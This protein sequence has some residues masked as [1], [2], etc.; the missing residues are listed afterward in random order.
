MGRNRNMN[1]PPSQGGSNSSS[2]PQNNGGSNTLSTFIKKWW[3]AMIIILIGIGLFSLIS[4]ETISVSQTTQKSSGE[5][6]NWW[7]LFPFVVV[8]M[9]VIIIFY[10]RTAELSIGAILLLIGTII[11]FWY[12]R[13]WFT[14]GLD[15][16][17]AKTGTVEQAAANKNDGGDTG[18]IDKITGHGQKKVYAQNGGVVTQARAINQESSVCKNP[19]EIATLEYVPAYGMLTNKPIL[20]T[21]NAGKYILEASGSHCQGFFTQDN[22][23]DTP[24]HCR[25]TDPNGLMD[26]GTTWLTEGMNPLSPAPF[27]SKPYGAVIYRIGGKAIFGGSKKVVTIQRNNQTIF[28]DLNVF[29]AER[30]FNGN[31]SFD[32]KISKCS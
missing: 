10:V 16:I 5:T 7:S 15:I 24:T 4:N 6:F 23:S 29:Q 21:V 2:T 25:W 20:A 12:N 17:D 18:I 13:H 9:M 22:T 26:D 3:W 32:I 11:F 30:V 14:P 31:G 19:K 28:V 27:A 8:A 1:Q